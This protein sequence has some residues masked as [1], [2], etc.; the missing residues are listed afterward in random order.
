MSLQMEELNGNEK[1]CYFDGSLPTEAINP[2]T[3]NAGDTF[4]CG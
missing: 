4:F 3:I 2:A 1:Y